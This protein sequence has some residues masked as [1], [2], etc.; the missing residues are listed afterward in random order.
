M[1]PRAPYT[2]LLVVIGSTGMYLA[3]QQISQYQQP[4][5][6]DVLSAAGLFIATSLFCFRL[7]FLYLLPHSAWKQWSFQ[8]NGHY[9]HPPDMFIQP[10]GN[11]LDILQG[12]DDRTGQPFV[13][14]RVIQTF[15]NGTSNG[16]AGRRWVVLAEPNSS[17]KSSDKAGQELSIITAKHY[18]IHPPTYDE[19]RNLG[20][21]YR[22]TIL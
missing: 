14:M 11:V 22:D 8:H 5:T 4:Q 17:F 7:L 3:W 18:Y 1:N 13:I 19:M 9:Y 16:L 15:R 21:E 12:I 20:S 10:Y 2:F 6:Y